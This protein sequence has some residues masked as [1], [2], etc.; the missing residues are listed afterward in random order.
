MIEVTGL[1]NCAKCFCETIEGTAREQIQAVCD[2][3]E[4]A[5][6]KIPSCRMFMPARAVLLVPQ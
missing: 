2:R 6:S 1:H 5:N 3:E 4:F